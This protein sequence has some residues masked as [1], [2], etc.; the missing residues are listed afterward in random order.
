MSKGKKK[1]KNPQI[2]VRTFNW[3]PCV[4]KLKI[5]D[6]F[7]KALLS[8][9]KKSSESYNHKLAGQIKKEIGYTQEARDKLIPYLATYLGIY[10]QML[11][12]QQGKRYDKKPEYAWSARWCNFQ[13]Q[14]ECNPPHDHD[15]KLSVVRYLSVAERLRKEN[16]ADTGK[17]CGPGGI[18]FMY[19]EGIRDCITYMSYFPKDGEMFVFPA[20]LK[21]WVSPFN[22]DCVR[23]SVSGNV[24]DSAPLNQ[25]KKGALVKE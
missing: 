11:Q 13:R 22:S 24:H 8:E 3:G 6:D 19:G 14:D 21:H 18:Q 9:I 25:I 23:V 20:W 15:G 1:E 4:I 16:E 2:E 10:D 5:Q 7:K 17:S 12:K